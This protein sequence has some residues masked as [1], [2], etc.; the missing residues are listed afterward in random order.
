M[1]VS[2]DA[3]QWKLDAATLQTRHGVVIGPGGKQLGYGELAD[4]FGDFVVPRITDTPPIAVHIVPSAAAPTGIGE[5]GLPSLAPAFANA[6]A[7]ITGRLA[8]ERQSNGRPAPF[9][10]LHAAAAFL[11]ASAINSQKLPLPTRQAAVTFAKER[12]HLECGG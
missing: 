10:R 1:L 2:A 6:V 8:R 9:N 12:P 5:P 3:A 7:A 4:S 11:I